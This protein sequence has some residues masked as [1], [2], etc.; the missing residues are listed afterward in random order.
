MCQIN[1]L[2][3]IEM[4]TTNLPRKQKSEANTNHS[5]LNMDAFRVVHPN[6]LFFCLR[7]F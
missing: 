3:Y 4:S 2:E 5:A 1:H 7:P 6:F